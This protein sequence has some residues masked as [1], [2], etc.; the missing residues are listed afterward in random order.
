MAQVTMDSKEYIELL[1]K[2]RA[3]DNFKKQVVEDTKVEL[4]G[5]MYGGYHITRPLGIPEES[6]M[7][8]AQKVAEVLIQSDDVMKKLVENK[9]V[10][11]D[12]RSGYL[13]INWGTQKPDEVDMLKIPAFKKKYEAI[14]AELEED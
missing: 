8:I 6:K 4:T 12:L 13:G 5:E 10:V 14:Q 3:W 9:E 11:L 2:S 7:T 1:D